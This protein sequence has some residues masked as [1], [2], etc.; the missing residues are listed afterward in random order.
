MGMKTDHPGKRDAERAFAHLK[1]QWL[2]Q[3]AAHKGRQNASTVH[4]LCTLEGNLTRKGLYLLAF[5]RVT[6]RLS[7]SGPG[8]PKPLALLKHWVP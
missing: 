1:F 5:G 3:V 2:E 6:L 8:V 4:S 7:F